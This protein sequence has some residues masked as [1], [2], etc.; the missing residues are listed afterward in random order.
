MA[1]YVKKGTKSKGIVSVWNGSKMPLSSELADAVMAM[2]EG[3]EQ[4]DFLEPEMIAARPMLEAQRRLSKLPQPGRLLIEQFRSR[5]G[6][7]LFVHPFA[8]RNVHIG[9]AQL[10][11]WRLA[12]AEPNTFS[13]SVNDYGFE[14]L[15]AKPIEVTAE[16]LAALFAPRDLMHDVLASLNSGEL[17]QR[18][19]REIARVAGLVFSGYPGAPK[20]L[21]QL[22]AS[23]SLFYEVFRKYD[24]GNRLLTQAENEVLAQELE[25]SRLR[26]VLQQMAHTP[27]ARVPLQTA[28]PFSLPLMVER[29]REQLSTE[30]LA[31]R[32][33]RLLADAEQAAAAPPAAPSRPNRRRRVSRASPA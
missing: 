15:A 20:S 9:L 14:V 32:L 26:A 6:H 10:V 29:L 33:A 17:A 3:A 19:F 18:R 16:S 30:K 4:G 1:A 22:Q 28:S 21:R 7:H 12:R 31:D 23:S 11:A 24:R 25:M 2:L 5:E 13:L 27:L 8:G